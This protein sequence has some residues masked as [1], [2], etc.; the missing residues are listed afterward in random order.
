MKLGRFDGRAEEARLRD[1]LA[2]LRLSRGNKQLTE[3]QVCDQTARRVVA[4]LQ[5][6]GQFLRLDAPR[7][8]FY[9]PRGKEVVPVDD[10]GWAWK[11]HV[12]DLMD[13]T[14]NAR[15]RAALAL[16]ARTARATATRVQEAR[17]GAFD[18]QN[19]LVAAEGGRVLSIGPDRVA[20]VS[21][22]AGG[23]LLLP[24]ESWDLPP[25]AAAK[26]GDPR[27]P[28]LRELATS[29]LSFSPESAATPAQQEA[30]LLAWMLLP[31][32]GD[33]VRDRPILLALGPKS[34]GKTTAVRA[35][36][37]ILLGESFDVSEPGSAADFRA[38]TTAMPLVVLD[39]V[40]SPRAWLSDA[41]CRASSGSTAGMRRKN[42]TNDLERHRADAV[43]A[44]TARTPQFR[45]A[46]VA[47]RLLIVRMAPRGTADRPW[48]SQREF[49]ERIRGSRPEIWRDIVACLQEVARQI[50]AGLQPVPV[51]TRLMDFAQVGAAVAGVLGLRDEF[52]GGLAAMEEERAA[53][54]VG[55]ETVVEPAGEV[56]LEESLAAL[57]RDD[58]EVA[59]QGFEARVLAAMLQPR[60]GRAIRQSL[61]PVTL[62]RELS[63]LSEKEDAPIV[64]KRRILDGRAIWSVEERKRRD[65]AA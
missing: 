57:V 42:T 56:A 36:G 13:T 45:R 51:Q 60:G 17:L 40:D 55:T 20:I 50:G 14:P 10:A 54:A 33:L 7:R 21:N 12:A 52:L 15:F 37:R 8:I 9:A 16:S 64:V 53:F 27:M 59:A 63:R 46:D 58:P 65:G 1:E 30:M 49:H 41:L 62:G 29:G 35:L 11:D 19:F 32:L 61:S 47:D 31:L 23:F 6:H 5:E 25:L 28:L 43:V 4:F 39:N 18:G 26:P 22:P 48:G 24:G 3:E 2:E 38:M 34:S 44:L